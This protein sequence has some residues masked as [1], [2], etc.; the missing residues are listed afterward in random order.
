MYSELNLTLNECIQVQGHAT[1]LT[2]TA[3]DDLNQPIRTQ[4]RE[5][6][7]RPTRISHK[8]FCFSLATIFSQ[9]QSKIWWRTKYQ[10]E[11]WKQSSCCFFLRIL[12]INAE[13]KRLPVIL[14]CD[15]WDKVIKWIRRWTI[16]FEKLKH[17]RRSISYNRFRAMQ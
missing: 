13:C 16:V 6:Q 8:E 5:A 12:Y 10:G 11:G 7:M 17:H 15:I 3:D 2:I 14:V 4:L 9:S 1:T